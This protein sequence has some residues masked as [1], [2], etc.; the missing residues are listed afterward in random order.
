MKFNFCKSDLHNV[1]CCLNKTDFLELSLSLA[2]QMNFKQSLVMVTSQSVKVSHNGS[3]RQGST[4]TTPD[5][6]NRIF[7]TAMKTCY[8]TVFFEL[9]KHITTQSIY[10]VLL[11]WL[12]VQLHQFHTS[13]DWTGQ[14]NPSYLQPEHSLTNI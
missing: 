1:V 12:P 9:E 14:T 6:C 4:S 11:P 3:M 7:C 5:R 13:K 8:C 2:T 10:T